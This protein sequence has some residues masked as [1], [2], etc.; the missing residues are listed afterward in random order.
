MSVKKAIYDSILSYS[1][2]E[3]HKDS[4]EKVEKEKKAVRIIS[5]TRLA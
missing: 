4:K 5:N 1:Q 3:W 2:N